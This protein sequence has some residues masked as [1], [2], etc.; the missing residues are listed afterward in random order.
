MTM[1]ETFTLYG[2][3]CDEPVLHRLMAA[4][5]DAVPPPQVVM[6]AT[7]AGTRV[8]TNTLAALRAV[9]EHS[10]TAGDARKVDRLRVD[11]RTND[12]VVTV[13][14]SDTATVTVESTDAAWTLGTAERIRR[15][16]SHAG[17]R[18]R[19]PARAATGHARRRAVI[20]IEG[21]VRQRGWQAW[22]VTDRTGV[23]ALLVAALAAVLRIF[24]G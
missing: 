10:L 5:C 8:R 20:R 3:R 23:V 16:L 22:S 11:A 24:T 1:V 14:L 7:W 4:I 2:C 15:I 18:A 13:D 12:R 17:G 21:R 6:E 9:Q 19:R